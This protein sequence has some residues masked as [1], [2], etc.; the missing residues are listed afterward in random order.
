MKGGV[1]FPLVEMIRNWRLVLLSVT[2]KQ[3][4]SACNEEKSC[5]IYQFRAS[6]TYLAKMCALDGHFFCMDSKTE[7]F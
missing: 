3:T 4:T 6:K 2:R 5:F 1:A 7:N